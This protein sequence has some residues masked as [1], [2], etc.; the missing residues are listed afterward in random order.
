MGRR[1]LILLGIVGLVV[2]AGCAG[3][4]GDDSGTET[5]TPQP[6]DET[7]E[8]AA[9]ST[10]E[11]TAAETTDSAE[12]GSDGSVAEAVADHQRQLE[13]SGSFTTTLVQNRTADDDTANVSVEIRS[14]LQ[15]DEYV[16][17]TT[18]IVLDRDL[19]LDR[20][21]AGDTTFE[22]VA[23]GSRERTRKDTE[24]YDGNVEPVDVGR[25]MGGK[26]LVG[27]MGEYDLENEGTVTHRGEEMTRYTADDP[28]AWGGPLPDGADEIDS[29]EMRIL[30]DDR[31]IVRMIEYRVSG[32][33]TSGGT[34]YEYF[35]LEI[36]DVG[37]TTVDE[38]AWID[39]EFDS[40]VVVD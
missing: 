22:R 10:D 33:S 29:L 31:G 28:D 37:S 38:P 34:F 5:T 19:Q 17:Q 4:L 39:E 7:T 11:T 6:T 36:T 27:K 32:T 23:L 3:F 14:D 24:P 16:M 15:A 13:S 2:T 20:Y 8:R 25:A 30:V 12:T 1:S 21:T 18:G 9:D 40:A 26:D 35:H